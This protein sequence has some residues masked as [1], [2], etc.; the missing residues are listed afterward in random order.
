MSNRL[1]D[2]LAGKEAN[3]ILPFL[4]QR[5][6]EESVIRE[7]MARVFEAGIRAVCVEAR[8]HPDFLGPRWWRDMDIIMEEARARDMRVWV[9]DDDH[10][11]TGHAAGKMKDAPAELRRSFLRENHLDA[12]GPRKNASFLVK[13]FLVDLFQPAE[14]GIKLVAVI[15]ARRDVENDRLDRKSVV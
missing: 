2:V 8:P 9:L 10:F 3:Y 1:E 14:E 7:E 6:E 5:G 4:W 11:P 12:I 13:P 15:A